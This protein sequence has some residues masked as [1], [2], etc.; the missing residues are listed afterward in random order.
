MDRFYK[1]EDEKNLFNVQ[2]NKYRKFKNPKISHIFNKTLVLSVIC[3]TCDSDDEKIFTEDSI[4]MLNIF[5]L[6]KN[7]VEYQV[8]I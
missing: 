6:I 3:D 1:D 8:N 7:M 2:C 4:E 5:G